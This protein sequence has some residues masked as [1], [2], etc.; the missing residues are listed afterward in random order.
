MG[1]DVPDIHLVIHYGPPSDVNDYLQEAGTTG[2][3]GYMSKAVLYCYPGAL[4]VHVSE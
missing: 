2:R 4:L 3:D 1:I